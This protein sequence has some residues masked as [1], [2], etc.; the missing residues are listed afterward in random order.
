[1]NGERFRRSP[2]CSPSVKAPPA[3]GPKTLGNHLPSRSGSSHRRFSPAAMDVLRRIKTLYEAGLS[4]EEVRERLKADFPSVIEVEAVPAGGVP[5]KSTAE[6][7]R[8]LLVELG[9]IRLEVQAASKAAE[10]V[11]QEVTTIRERFNR[12]EERE[13]E[14]ARKLD[15]LIAELREQRRRPWW[16]KIFRRS[17]RK[18]LGILWCNFSNL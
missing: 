10:K 14:R 12:H 2:A 15:E 7:V 17:T 8:A 3:D 13:I 4:T 16:A 11:Q 9:Q 5:P 1:M 6:P 18:D